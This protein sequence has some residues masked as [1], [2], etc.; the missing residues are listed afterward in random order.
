M[1]RFVRIAPLVCTV[2]LLCTDLAVARPRMA[3]D[4]L[5]QLWRWPFQQQMRLAGAS[6]TPATAPVVTGLLRRPDIPRRVQAELRA[7][8]AG[9]YLHENQPSLA[10][11]QMLQTR[12]MA[13]EDHDSLRAAV[14]CEWL[15]YSYYLLKQPQPGIA[16]GREALQLVPRYTPAGYRELGSIYANLA[17]CALIAPDY[18]LAAYCDRQGLQLARADHDT[19][20]IAV[21]LNN[22]AAIA[23][24]QRQLPRMATLLDSAYAAYPPPRYVG[25][26]IA[27]DNLKGALAYEQ[28]QYAA[29]AQLLQTTLE[30][31]HA[32]RQI[33]DEMSVLETLV[34]TLEKLGRY[35]EALQHQR[36]YAV[37]QDSLF[38]ESS[39]RHA[40]E[41]QTLYQTQQKEQ[42]L[43]QQRQR[44]ANLQV[45]TRLRE[46]EL[47]RRTT[48]FLAALVG[49]GIMLVLVLVRQRARH[50]LESAAAALRMR[51]RI[52]A[53][54]HDEVGT[55]LTRVNLQAELLRQNKPDPALDRLLSNSRA[56]A[57]TMR[58]IVWS[59]D[60]QADTVGA[61]LDRMRDHLDQTAAAAGLETELITHGLS[62]QEALSPELRQHLYL[63][64]KEAVTNAVRHAQ[65]AT[66]LRV[67]LTR[68]QGHLLLTIDDDGRSSGTAARSGMGLR[69]MQQRAA[70]LRGTL[71]AA[72]HEQG[73][74][75]VRLLVPAH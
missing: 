3:V 1:S 26:Q 59:I 45:G 35:R 23:Y 51:N 28:G 15:C 21:E 75:G 16:Y 38:E 20:N 10:I 60:A 47:T 13:L 11:M 63:V 6:I 73:G 48:L 42:Q 14:A 5:R 33:H 58:D 4:S 71:L 56:A 8:L 74:F 17:S 34:P 72:P 67:V 12:R 31:S 19:A 69:N 40:R 9:Y 25:V 44:I 41:L 2:L 46:A 18:K 27:L 32:H 37:L 22:L 57:S 70:A 55:L 52:A 61:L 24:K 53:D 65:H 49:A 36:R 39:A 68:Q 54:L 50:L 29:A 66:M 64:F 7:N 43:A 30:T 62:D